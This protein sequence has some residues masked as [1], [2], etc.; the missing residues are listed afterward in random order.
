MASEAASTRPPPRPPAPFVVGVSRS[1]TTLLRLML[2]AHPE[3]A[4]PPETNFIPKLARALDEGPAT[5]EAAIAFLAGRRRWPDLGLDAG[6]LRERLAGSPQT[7]ATAVTRTVFDLY[8]E[9]RGKPRWGDK[10]PAF[11]AR[12]PK[13]HSVLPEARFVHLIRDGRAVALSLKRAEFGP[14]TAAEAAELWAKRIRR[15][16]RAAGRVPHYKE[17]RYEQLVADPEPHLRAICEFAELDFEPAMLDYHRGAAE[18]IGESARTMARADGS[19]ITAAER[20]V[21]HAGVADPPQADLA[22][23]WR[24]ELSAAELADVERVAGELL[25]ELGYSS[26]ERSVTRS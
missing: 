15:A 21:L 9:A 17:V 8:A 23:R 5:P 18:R 24:E 11:V 26:S 22:E 16:R 2:D 25:V 3:L 6:E 1:G 7:T 19:E 14:D 4:I 20:A 13:V 12:M 10:T